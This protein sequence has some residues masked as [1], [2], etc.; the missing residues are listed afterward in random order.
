MLTISVVSHYPKIGDSPEEQLLRRSIAQLDRKEITEADLERVKDGV[1]RIV[2]EEQVE[3]GVE[4]VTDGLI[5]W[6]D[7]LTYIAGKIEGF[8]VTGLLRY[9]DTNTFY[10][11]PICQG[12]LKSPDGL[13]VKDFQFANTVSSVPVKVALIGPYTLSRLSQDRHYKD[14][15]EFGKKL[16]AILGEEV[17]RLAQAGAAVIQFEEPAL[18]NFKKEFSLFKKIWTKLASYFPEDIEIIL[19]LNFGNLE[20]LY[21]EILD[22]PFTTLGLDLAS[23]PENWHLLGNGAFQKKLLAGIVDA[24]N[25]KMETEEEIREKLERLINLASP[26][27]L[28]VS[29]NYG[30]EFL[31]RSAA[32]KKLANLSR[33][34]REFR[35][36]KVK[37]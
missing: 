2:I 1:T 6:G 16:A 7:P 26:E 35:E 11:Q 21:P 13:V 29:P 12:E 30:L 22:L 23:Q 14:P 19:F 10:R 32:K 24:R 4:L 5:R 34:V 9:F 8:R 28:S 27:K 17:K 15:E 33:I 20:G 18:L 3:A 31:P 25:T 37:A 36:A